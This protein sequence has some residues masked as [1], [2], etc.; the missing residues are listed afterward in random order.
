MH[1]R[2]VIPAA[3]FFPDFR[4]GGIRQLPAEIH[5]YLPG[6]GNG[7]APFFADSILGG[8]LKVFGYDLYYI[9][10]GDNLWLGIGQ[11]IL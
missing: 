3:E 1:D 6:V 5:G 10:D 8:E 11:N 7:P 2:C 9:F 4:Q